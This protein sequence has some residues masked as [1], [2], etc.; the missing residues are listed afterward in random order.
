M[1]E[2]PRQRKRMSRSFSVEAVALS[3]YQLTLR[4]TCNAASCSM[5]CAG[6]FFTE[7]ALRSPPKCSSSARTLII[8]GSCC[9]PA[10]APLRWTSIVRNHFGGDAYAS[11]AFTSQCDGEPP[12]MRNTSLMVYRPVDWENRLP[13]TVCNHRR[14]QSGLPLQETRVQ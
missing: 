6:L 8:H 7:E 13:P 3:L 4:L 1:N 10:R 9:P 2:T 14:K 5:F 12:V 11:F